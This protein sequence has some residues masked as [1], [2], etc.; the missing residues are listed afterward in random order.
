MAWPWE[1]VERDHEIQNATSPEKIRL[2]GEHLRLTPASRVLDIACGKAG[3]ALI[4]ASTFGCHILGIEV[5]EASRPRRVRA[6]PQQ[7]S[8]R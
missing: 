6:S 7:G 1:I 3:P 8:S 4:L 5:R 2:L